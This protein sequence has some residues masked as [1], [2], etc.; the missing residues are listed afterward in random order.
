MSSQR[1][2][3]ARALERD[4]WVESATSVLAEDPTYLAAWLIGS[5][6]RDDFDEWSD[7]D[8][9]VVVSN[10]HAVSAA[11]DAVFGHLGSVLSTREVKANAP[12]GGRF[13]TVIYANAFG[14][15]AVDWHWQPKKKAVVPADA[16][17]LFDKLGLALSVSSHEDL[18]PP[19]PYQ[20]PKDPTEAAAVQVRYFWAMIP[21]T[22]K[23]IGR[24]WSR[25]VEDMIQ[26]LERSAGEVAVFVDEPLHSPSSEPLSRLRE[27]MTQMER[28]GELLQSRS[29]DVRADIALAKEAVGFIDEYP[30]NDSEEAH[31]PTSEAALATQSV[32]LDIQHPDRCRLAP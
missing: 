28:F 30:D 5:L 1:L 27:L 21:T 22:C 16:R 7:V 20:P 32:L 10:Q 8:L 6:A 31:E 19:R 13:V 14:P 18:H 29:V 12:D 4:R 23:F 2:L 24:G 3:K 9:V 26:M 15:L 17:V 11:S 25:S